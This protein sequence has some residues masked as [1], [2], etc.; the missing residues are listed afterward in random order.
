M[1]TTP[2][3][4]RSALQANTL[5]PDFRYQPEIV[6]LSNGN[7]LVVWTDEN[8]TAASTVN[9]DILGQLYDIQ[10]EPIG[11]NIF[12]NE[13]YGAG[14]IQ[15]RP[16]VSAT[17]DG[18]FV[19][20]FDYVTNDQ[21]DILFTRFD[22][23]LNR[24][25]GTFAVD[26][27]NTSIDYS[28]RDAHFRSTDA[29]TVVIYDRTEGGAAVRIL[30]SNGFVNVAESL[31]VDGLFSSA[32]LT[33]ERVIVVWNEAFQGTDSNGVPIGPVIHYPSFKIIGT[34][35]SISD[36]FRG[37]S[38]NDPLVEPRVAALEDGGWVLAYQR[39][40][41]SVGFEVYADD[42][43][44]TV[45]KT[46]F[47]ASFD[48]SGSDW[49]VIGL[50]GGGFFVAWIDQN[51]N[52]LLGQRFDDGALEV[53]NQVTDIARFDFAGEVELG[54]T[55]DGRILVTYRDD[56]AIE[57]TILDPRETIISV[58]D[59]TP[60]TALKTLG[61]QIA[62]PFL[63]INDT[64]FGQN[65]N[66]TLSG[67][68]G[69]DFLAGGLGDDFLIGGS[70]DDQIFGDGGADTLQGDDGNDQLFGLADAD[71]I[72]GGFGFDTISG[73]EG[74]DSV[75]AGPDNDVVDGDA[76]ADTLFGQFGFDLLRGGEGADLIDGGNGN[77]TLEGGTE[78]DTLRGGD[79]NDQLFGGGSGDQLLGDRGSDFLFG[80]NGDD[81]LRGG[82]GFDLLN[83]GA[84]DDVLNG[85]NG[86][87]RLFGNT[88]NDTLL[89]EA[90]N[91]TFYGG[92]SGNDVLEGGDDDDLL[93][94]EAGKD[95][96]QGD[97]GNDTLNGGTNDDTLLGGNG[98]DSLE[99]GA[100]N[101]QLFGGPTGAD[102]LKGG[103]GS[104]FLFAESSDDVLEGGDGFDLMNGGAGDDLMRGG[105]GNDRL[106]GN[107]GADTLEGG[108]GD[109]ELFGGNG[110]SSDT[111]DGGTGN[112]TLAGEA[113]AD[114]FIFADGFGIDVI[115]DFDEFSA[116]EVIDL[117]L[118]SAITDF[119]DLQANHLSQNGANAVITDGANSIT[120]NNVLIADLG[121][122]DFDFV[123]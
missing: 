113:G 73:G 2:D 39:P 33:D 41:G 26:V 120:L 56:S 32:K 22:S 25:V 58:T 81:L 106:E 74:N 114:T 8:D 71:I 79:D 46:Y 45:L 77:D 5:S 36:K 66:D 23:A 31:G 11:S 38:G 123:V 102:T 98:D 101:D 121:A 40:N 10:G 27:G 107:L 111:L 4:W 110:G 17:D 88:G 115:T 67:R 37:N 52:V 85:G 15:S 116:A 89:G 65:G 97:D 72:W 82:D 92:P 76:G 86:N 78:D 54:L 60:T 49:D 9:S 117:S 47:T 42:G 1:P 99:G 43:V 19:L 51:N 119:A 6:G 69:D 95:F 12:L 57:S 75:E 96:L 18:G 93:F 34:D 20:L 94:G 28:I 90:G 48:P 91:D 13:T 24:T 104:D 14:R 16:T 7:Y 55:A 59:G 100:G 21:E 70:G 35:D 105:N 122:D 63:D 103:Q 84:D 108:S 3:I 109:D 80:E 44:R 87:D 30:S 64:F 68:L 112:D 53:G 118:V 29:N 61:T 50:P 62:T 83:G